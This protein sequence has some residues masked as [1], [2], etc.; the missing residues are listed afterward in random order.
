MKGRGHSPRVGKRGSMRPR[1]GVG[2][3]MKG[4]CEGSL[5]WSLRGRAPVWE[6]TIGPEGGANGQE[7]S[8]SEGEAA[9]DKGTVDMEWATK[10]A[11]Q[12]ECPR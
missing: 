3:K 7:C 10:E 1:T 8:W 5:A 11:E 6:G 12:N 2:R 4:M 9:L